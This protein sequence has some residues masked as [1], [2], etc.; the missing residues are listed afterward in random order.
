M[1]KPK[2][3]IG[4]GIILSGLMIVV[5]LFGCTN[6][7]ENAEKN[8]N[9]I[10]ILANDLGYGDVSCFNEDLKNIT[11]NLDKLAFE[12]VKLYYEKNSVK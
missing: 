11:P 5:L 12:G 9:N 3:S 8:P 6:P 1:M 4:K 2:T 10:F 7:N